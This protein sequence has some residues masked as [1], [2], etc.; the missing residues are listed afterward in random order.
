MSTKKIIFFAVVIVCLA[1]AAW[2]YRM[3]NKPRAGVADQQTDRTLSAAELYRLYAANEHAADSMFLGKVI[4]VSGVVQ[5]V[6]QSQPNAPTIL[7]ETGAA[8]TINCSMQPGDSKP[9]KQGM[10]L[11][12]KGKCTGFLMDVNL[13]DA[14]VLP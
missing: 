4:A 2:G 1:V 13:V 9:I 6:D 12:V 10:Q 14:I 7:L 11:Q 8:G 5:S 3:Y